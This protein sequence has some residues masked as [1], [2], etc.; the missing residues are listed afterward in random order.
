MTEK[1]Y[2]AIITYSL[3]I[4][5][6]SEKLALEIASFSI[7]WHFDMAGCGPDGAAKCKF[8]NGSVVSV[9]PAVQSAC[10]GSERMQ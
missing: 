3:Q 9:E 6:A 7:P 1:S 10:H 2:T 4:S 8:Q 5:A